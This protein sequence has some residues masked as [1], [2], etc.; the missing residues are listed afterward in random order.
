[1]STMAIKNLL[2]P[3]ILL[4]EVTEVAEVAV[5]DELTEDNNI[6]NYNS[7]DWK[8]LLDF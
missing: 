8:Q 5:P 7:I 2:V 3:T 6:N 4:S 1:M